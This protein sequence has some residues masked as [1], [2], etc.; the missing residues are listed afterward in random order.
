M[1]Y[2]SCTA[3]LLVDVQNDF[4]PNGALAVKNGNT[5]IP[6]INTIIHN[7][8][9]VI[10]TVDWHPPNHMSF[11]SNHK[12][13]KQG[14]VIMID[15]HQQILWPN[16]CIENTVGSQFPPTLHAKKIMHIIKKGTNPKVDSYSGFYDNN[17]ITQT[18]LHNLLCSMHINTLHICGLATD[19]CVHHTICDALKLGYTTI[20]HTDGC[21]AV[22]LNSDDEKI[23]LE[24]MV[25]LGAKLLTN[26]TNK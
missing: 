2:N 18:N 15:G 20:L 3:L 25:C 23:A 16:H 1:M 5:I 14:D 8:N 21:R 10:A 6:Y 24:H 17:K 19:Y 26:N 4:L 9:T 12:D 22:N 13:K 7:Y 11:A